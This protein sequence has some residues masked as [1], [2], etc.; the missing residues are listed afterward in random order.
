MGIFIR[1]ETAGLIGKA[2]LA[3]SHLIVAGCA[4]LVLVN[5]LGFCLLTTGAATFLLIVSNAVTV[6]FTL[7][8]FRPANTLIQKALL[9][10]HNEVEDQQV[11]K[12]RIEQLERENNEL[13]GRLDTRYQTE[14]MAGSLNFTFKLEQMEFAKKGYIVKEHGLDALAADERYKDLVPEKGGFSKLLEMLR[15]KEG[16]LKKILYIRK[17][18]YK[19]SIGIDFGKIKYAIDADRICFA[20]VRFSK[21]HDISGEMEHDEAD[22]DRCLI[23]NETNGGVKVEQGADYDVLM[24]A[25]SSVQAEENREF[26]ERE[27]DMICREYTDV[28]QDSLSGKFRFIRFVEDDEVLGSE[29]TWYALREGARDRQVSEVASNMIMLADVMSQTTACDR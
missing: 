7:L 22:I 14:S 20:G 29:L 6:L 25:Y 17:S 5:V 2:G 18:Y 27:V 8:A 1:K 11:L 3:K 9:E 4:I 13:A 10:A 19:A 24:Q 28:L 15:L 16:G 23:L 26:L 12:N 21:L